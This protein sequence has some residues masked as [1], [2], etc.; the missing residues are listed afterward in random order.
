MNI[1]AT[2]TKSDEISAEY[3]HLAMVLFFAAVA[4][5]LIGLL[6][7]I[8]PRAP[9]RL[10]FFWSIGAVCL[11]IYPAAFSVYVHHL[12]FIAV[13]VDGTRASEPYWKALM[14]PFSPVVL[15]LLVMAFHM[16]SRKSRNEPL[17][18]SQANS[19]RDYQHA[20]PG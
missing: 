7:V 15:G 9:A 14:I 19:E 11:G 18:G 2:V 1:I 16:L 3:L 10:S 20:T 12:D 13:G 17:P 8:L 5:C 6:L 4:A